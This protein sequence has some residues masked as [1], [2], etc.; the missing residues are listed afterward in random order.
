M[1]WPTRI[2]TG[3]G[4]NVI[5]LVH[6]IFCCAH[7]PRRLS[8]P[9]LFWFALAKIQQTA[10]QP[11]SQQ[12]GTPTVAPLSQIGLC[13]PV[14]AD[15]SEWC[16]SWRARFL[17]ERLYMC[18]RCST[19]LPQSDHLP[20]A[21]GASLHFWHLEERSRV[22]KACSGAED[23]ASSVAQMSCESEVFP[24]CGIC[25]GGPTSYL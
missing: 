25:R 13:D 20:L 23:D 12:P 3:L 10:I 7:W 17:R 2:G 22:V 1:F 4:P 18:R 14:K 5:W 21:G 24:H 8:L 16:D 19:S 11:L 15:L 6:V 9:L